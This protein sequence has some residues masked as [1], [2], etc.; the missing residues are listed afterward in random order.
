[1]CICILVRYDNELVV[2]AVSSISFRLGL[3]VA[4][5]SVLIEVAVSFSETLT[6]SPVSI[7]ARIL[8]S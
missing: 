2:D 8:V 7:R 4:S 6:Y 5:Y 3:V 1:L